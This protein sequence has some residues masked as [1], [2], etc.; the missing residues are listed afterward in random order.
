MD[1][2]EP[3]SRRASTRDGSGPA[4]RVAGAI[5]RSVDDAAASRARSEQAREGPSVQDCTDH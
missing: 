4:S 3:V 2:Y 1:V 5:G